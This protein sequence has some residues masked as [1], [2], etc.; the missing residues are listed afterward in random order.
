MKIMKQNPITVL[1]RPGAADSVRNGRFALCRLAVRCLTVCAALMQCPA[2]ARAGDVPPVA[3][4]DSR[5]IQAQK[6]PCPV[7]GRE[8]E[9]Y[10]AFV[11]QADLP[12]ITVTSNIL[13]EVGG[14]VKIDL[15]RLAQ[16]SAQEEGAL[17]ELFR[18]PVAVVV[19]PVQQVAKNSS[20]TA[21]RFAQ[22]L[23]T[24]VIDY[25]FLR[26]EWDRYHPPTAGQ[27]AK[28]DA[29]AALEAG[30]LAKAWELY[31]GLARPQPPAIARPAPP[32]NL[33]VVA[34]P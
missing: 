8:M 13:I 19:K 30:E 29:L 24:A 10:K 5:P 23:R 31:D 34:G 15:T 18:V 20:T 12:L 25:R 7:L 33:R 28:S 9:R 1:R 3:E 16:L 2:P 17:A 4:P 14:V 6:P 26:I 22:E 32:T 27:Q 21:D 11:R